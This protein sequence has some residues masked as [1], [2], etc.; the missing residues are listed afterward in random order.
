MQDFSTAMQPP[1]EDT[2]AKARL[3]EDPTDWEIET[4]GE[5]LLFDGEA[6]QDWMRRQVSAL[7]QVIDPATGKKLIY[8]IYR[9]WTHQI[10]VGNDGAMPEVS[11]FG[12][13]G[14]KVWDEQG[15]IATAYFSSDIALPV[16]EDHEEVWM[17]LSP[18]E[19]LTC[20]P[21]IEAAHGNVLIGG[22]SLGWMAKAIAALPHVASVTVVEIDQDIADLF[23][24]G[25][26][27]AHPEKM[28]GVFVADLWQWLKQARSAKPPSNIEAGDYDSFILDIWPGWGAAQIDPAMQEFRGWAEA[29][30]KTLWAWGDVNDEVIMRQY[31][32]EPR[33][34]WIEHPHVP[35]SLAN[36]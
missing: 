30:N 11:S 19:I 33:L 13:Q 15:R 6:Y 34:R 2:L 5:T 10:L 20:T 23:G 32:S 16:L 35:V 9:A 36:G 21:G 27:A 1:D 29:S 8:K 18:M 12:P 31:L 25:L 7:P 24:P 4:P 28:A 26:Y 17:S 3:I 14:M 22:M